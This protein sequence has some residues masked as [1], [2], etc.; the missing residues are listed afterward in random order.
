M[1]KY[2]ILPALFVLALFSSCSLDENP[3]SAMLEK[4]AFSN[5]QLIY[6]NS[7][8]NVYNSISNYLYGHHN[9]AV[10][11]LEE[12]TSDEMLTPGRISDFVDGGKWQN[13]FLHNFESSTNNYQHVWNNLYTMIGQANSS[14]DKLSQFTDNASA[15]NYIYEVRAL[16]AIFYYYLL[17]LW[18]QVPLVT[19]SETSI[20]SVAQSSRS[21][22][23]N[24][25]AS[26]LED[27]LPHLANA[28]SQ[29]EGTYYGRVTKPVAYMCLAKLAMNSPIYTID[30]TSPTSYQAFVGDDLTK[31]NT[32]SEEKGEMVTNLGKNIKL[33]VDGTER[34][35]WETVIYCVEQLEKAGYQLQ[36]N[37]A[38]NFSLT[39][40][41]SVE[42][43][44]TRPND[45]TT[46]QLKD[47]M[48]IRSLHYNH[49]SSA[50]YKGWN[51][52]A[53]SIYAMNVYGYGTD[54]VDPRLKLNFYTGTDYTDDT[55]KLVSDGA[56]D[57]NLEY[58]P[59]KVKLNYTAS[60]D[61][62]DVKCGGARMKKYKLDNTTGTAGITN[63]DMVIW[64][65]SDALLLKAEAQYRM[66]DKADALENVNK[67][68]NRVS[69]TPLTSISLQDI[70]NERVLELM[71][72]GVRR[73]DSQRYCT[74]T[75]PTVD[76]YPGVAH[77][78]QAGDYNNDLQGY[79]YLLPIPFE[80]INLNNNLH[81][82]PGYDK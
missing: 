58:E 1:K 16:R 9:Y 80:A 40:D 69:A 74:Y 57:K 6:A 11:C 41:A 22:V 61:P 78:M 20:S 62:H 26:E 30:A 47:N 2:F 29:N 81:Q 14:I 15:Q 10:Y 63:N 46:Y 36:P 66:G 75:Q 42:N 60:D 13:M 32:V 68:R 52:S 21:E 79:T 5:S 48:L 43:I 73:M 39:N 70:A 25:V 53:A 71:W 76:K 67:V 28:K 19:S 44:F 31:N 4:D 56:T 77:N 18:G 7:V 72:E 50:K 24:F 37:Y 38:D 49:A 12:Y 45:N 55:G 64:R 51:G 33:T 34:N 8:A 65:Y 23:F 35:A 17:D 27:C 54:K 59:L 82:N 3:K